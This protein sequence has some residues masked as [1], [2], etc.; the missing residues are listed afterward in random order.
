MTDPSGR[1]L[2]SMAEEVSQ[3]TGRYSPGRPAFSALA[4]A[5]TALKDAAREVDIARRAYGPPA[6]PPGAR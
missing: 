1:S 2:L 6:S 5:E 3:L 4:R